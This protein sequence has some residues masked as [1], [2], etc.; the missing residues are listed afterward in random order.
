VSA[1]E[2]ER[3]IGRFNPIAHPAA[4]IRRSALDAVG[5]YDPRYRRC[6]DYDLWLRIAARWPLANLEQPL[7]RYRI[8]EGQAKQKHLRQSLQLTIDIQRKW[9]WHPR[10]RSA[11][12]LAYFAAEHALLLLPETLVMGLFTRMTYEPRRT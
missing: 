11:L 6:Q 1:A 4:T 5:G 3:V 10:F 12:N 9:L 8:S 7:L 2:I